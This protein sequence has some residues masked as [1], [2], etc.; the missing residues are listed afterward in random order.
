MPQ[1]WAMK[2]ALLRIFAPTRKQSK[3]YWK[4][5]L[6]RDT[7]LEKIV[8]SHWIQQPV[9]F[10][11]GSRTYSRKVISEHCR[12]IRWSNTGRNGLRSIRLS[13]LKTGWR[14]TIGLAGRP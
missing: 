3:Q 9:S 2:V 12:V 11:M 1:A 4:R 8:Y 7:L 5:S 10:T 14:K 6:R 13:R